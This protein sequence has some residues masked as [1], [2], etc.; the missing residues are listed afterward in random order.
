[1]L[2]FDI[3]VIM[4]DAMGNSDIPVCRDAEITYGRSGF[5]IASFTKPYDENVGF[6]VH[7]ALTDLANSLSDGDVLKIEFCKAT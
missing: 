4:P 3:T 1:M 5:L 7:C 6:A 2:R